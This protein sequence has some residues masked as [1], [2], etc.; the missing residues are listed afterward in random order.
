MAA[1]INITLGSPFFEMLII[2]IVMVSQ[3]KFFTIR[4]I[5]LSFTINK[6]SI[7]FAISFDQCFNLRFNPP[8]GSL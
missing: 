6:N 3:G 7:A 5:T 2:E 4:T 8:I 1:A